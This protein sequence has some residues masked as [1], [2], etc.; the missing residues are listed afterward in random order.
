MKGID[1]AGACRDFAT[2]L[3]RVP[4]LAGTSD[5]SHEEPAECVRKLSSF[6]EPARTF[7]PVLPARE[8]REH[9]VLL[10]KQPLIRS[11]DPPPLPLLLNCRCSSLSLSVL[12]LS[13]FLSPSPTSHSICFSLSSPFLSFLSYLSQNSIS[14]LCL[15][16]RLAPSSHPVLL[17]LHPVWRSLLAHKILPPRRCRPRRTLN[18]G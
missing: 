12:S 10:W 15:T 16:A 13:G 3:L 4:L 11:R 2:S 6:C 9:C 18:F 17:L 8:T 14:Q 5:E 7:S 1:T